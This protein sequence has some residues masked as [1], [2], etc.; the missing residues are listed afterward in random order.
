[1]PDAA[2][3][4]PARPG[5]TAATKMALQM[6]VALA[7][8][9]GAGFLV[10]PDHWGWTVLTAFIVCSG[11][12]GRGDAAYKGVLRLAGAIGGTI[13]A[14][15]SAHVWAPA[16]V[17]E[18]IVI[19]GLLFFA[20]LL[21]EINYAFWAAGTTLILAL[22]ARSGDGFDLALLGTRLEAILTGALCAVIAAWFVFP[23][24]T[25]DVIRRRLADALKALDDVVVHAHDPGA[26]D[27][28]IAHLDHRMSELEG[29]APPV[30]WHRRIFARAS[31]PEH[32]ACWIDLAHEIT[33]TARA[34]TDG[35]IA[36]EK[37]RGRL[38]RAIGA[39]RK[40]IGQHR[41]LAAENRVTIGTALS[42]LRDTVASIAPR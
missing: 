17:A 40:A 20:L 2:A 37:Q 18:A 42:E 6:A 41:D 26:R 23:I 30:R 14:A 36:D 9:F 15:V 38:R 7:A 1:V 24:S 11:A 8:A 21:R 29:V 3:A 33:H 5:M 25:E 27:G 10:F 28:H 39:S 19:F 22:L 16:G 32:P 13:V 12:R 35:P 31:S 34:V 4:A